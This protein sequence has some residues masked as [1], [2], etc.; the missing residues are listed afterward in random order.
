MKNLDNK[1]IKDCDCTMNFI[2]FI[3]TSLLFHNKNFV[4]GFWST[5]FSCFWYKD[6][7]FTVVLE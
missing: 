6:F 2:Y 4:G 7:Q 3:D 1:D 5:K